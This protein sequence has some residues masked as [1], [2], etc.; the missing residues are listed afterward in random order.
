MVRLIGMQVRAVPIRNVAHRARPSTAP[1]RRVPAVAGAVLSLQRQAGNRAVSA[2]LNVQR[3]D[4]YDAK[5]F[6]PEDDTKI[7]QVIN[8]TEAVHLLPVGKDGKR[9]YPYFDVKAAAAD[10]KAQRDEHPYDTNLACAEHY[11]AARYMAQLGIGL[12]PF[13]AFESGAYQL[14]K[15]VVGHGGDDP[16]SPRTPASAKQFEWAM[17][18]SM[19]GASDLM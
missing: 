11:M 5:K 1:A 10:L 15:A 18:G 13:M 7:K 19:D 2:L 3:D 17:K 16:K 9:P 6:T 8:D 4:P 12:P 14:F